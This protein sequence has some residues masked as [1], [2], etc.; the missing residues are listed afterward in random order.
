MS[1]K[2]VTY[3]VFALLCASFTPQLSASLTLLG[4]TVTGSQVSRVFHVLS[5]QLPAKADEAMTLNPEETADFKALFST[6]QHHKVILSSKLPYLQKVTDILARRQAA[7]MILELQT[8]ADAV[9]KLHLTFAFDK[10]FFR[11]QLVERLMLT[12]TTTGALEAEEKE[13]FA[14]IIKADGFFVKHG[15]K[16][17]ALL[18]LGAAGWAT[19]EETRPYHTAIDNLGSQILEELDCSDAFYETLRRTPS[20]KLQ[21]SLQD[22]DNTKMVLVGMV[23]NDAKKS[24]DVV[25]ALAMRGCLGGNKEKKQ[26]RFLLIP[27]SRLRACAP[28]C[29][30]HSTDLT[31]NNWIILIINDSEVSIPS[32]DDALMAWQSESFLKEKVFAKLLQRGTPLLEDENFPHYYY[33]GQSLFSAAKPNYTLRIEPVRLGGKKTIVCSMAQYVSHP[34]T[35][36]V[37]VDHIVMTIQSSRIQKHV[38]ALKKHLSGVDALITT[39]NLLT[40]EWEQCHVG[41]PAKAATTEI[42]IIPESIGSSLSSY[43]DY[44]P[45]GNSIPAKALCSIVLVIGDQY[46][47]ATTEEI[48]GMTQPLT[49]FKKHFDHFCIVTGLI[50]EGVNT[51]SIKYIVSKQRKPLEAYEDDSAHDAEAYYEE[52]SLAVPFGPSFD[53]AYQAAAQ[54][55]RKFIPNNDKPK[56]E[57]EEETEEQRRAR[58]EEAKRHAEEAEKYRQLLAT[59]KWSVE[60]DEA[61]EFARFQSDVLATQKTL[62]NVARNAMNTSAEAA[63]LVQLL[64]D[65]TVDVASADVAASEYRL[66]FATPQHCSK[67]KVGECYDHHFLTKGRHLIIFGQTSLDARTSKLFINI[68]KDRKQNYIIKANHCTPSGAEWR[69]IPSADSEKILTYQD[70]VIEVVRALINNRKEYLALLTPEDWAEIVRVNTPKPAPNPRGG[71]DVPGEDDP[72]KDPLGGGAGPQPRR[73]KPVDVRSYEEKFVQDFLELTDAQSLRDQ[74]ELAKESKDICYFPVKIAR[75][76]TKAIPMVDRADNKKR[77]VVIFIPD[78]RADSE[79]FDQLIA[80][81]TKDEKGERLTGEVLETQLKIIA[82]VKSSVFLVVTPKEELLTSEYV[83]MHY[84]D[85]GKSFKTVTITPTQLRNLIIAKSAKR[86]AEI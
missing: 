6:P 25:E 43:A 17:L 41:D 7:T 75:L 73:E 50:A 10:E 59:I 53:G 38:Q 58:E 49:T 61:D 56:P 21:Q 5:A 31:E 55:I 18:L 69:Q 74:T 70:A 3:A 63:D 78:T 82:T 65:N 36:H 52:K 11:G 23:A 32:S 72:A 20:N 34:A 26:T 83:K 33:F 1:F 44:L 47:G 57:D 24:T 84:W 35:T 9:K 60:T 54:A 16:A 46:T 81:T 12:V 2:N 85:E 68:Y 29:I 27:L 80:N 79:S 42:V 48:L 22:V 62:D 45:L 8:S 19:Y 39:P 4:E 14:T 30:K 86:Q 15:V 40:K 28:A 64:Q 13:F 66:V 51:S 77:V 37:L 76:L 67:M 71:D